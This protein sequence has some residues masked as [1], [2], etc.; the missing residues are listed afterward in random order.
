MATPKKLCAACCRQLRT[1]YRYRYPHVRERR[2][3]GSDVKQTSTEQ[4]GD[5]ADND[6]H[7]AH[8]TPHPTSTT[9]GSAHAEARSTTSKA[10]AVTDALQK[11]EGHR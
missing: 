3:G 4:V 2:K 9:G 8:G 5:A 11:R 10:G 7:T 6:R 1:R